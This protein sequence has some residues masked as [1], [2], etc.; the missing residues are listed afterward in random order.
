MKYSYN[1]I[2]IS[3]LTN[4]TS[5]LD[6]INIP[7]KITSL[8]SSFKDSS[9]K[10][11]FLKGISDESVIETV[12]KQNTKPSTIYSYTFFNEDTIRHLIDS[13]QPE[14]IYIILLRGN[15]GDHIKEKYLDYVT[16][17]SK[18]VKVIASMDRDDLKEKYA[19]SFNA[20][21]F[22]ATI[23][24]SMHDDNKKAQ[25]LDGI[26]EWTPK[27]LR[28]LISIKSDKIKAKYLPLVDPYYDIEV[29]ASME[30]DD[31]KTSYLHTNS[32]PDFNQCEEDRFTIVESLSRDTLKLKELGLQEYFPELFSESELKNF[33]SSETKKSTSRTL[34][35]QKEEEQ[36]RL[37]AE[38]EALNLRL[39]QT[40]NEIKQYRNQLGE[41]EPDKISDEAD[42]SL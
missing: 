3:M 29:V 1:E 17:P 24:A 25:Y 27:D 16:E 39:Q 34:L 9:I 21:A 8:L 2:L 19:Q 15:F 30:D 5:V 14:S 11:K 41:E 4:D 13:D 42:I 33:S 10:N 20:H 28:V 23:Y 12:Y 7:P 22:K 38:I 35:S 36:R 32:H 18:K 37:E 6:N 40:K 31:F 26:T